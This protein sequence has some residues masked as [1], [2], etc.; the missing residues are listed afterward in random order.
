MT[1]YDQFPNFF[2]IGAPKSG[3]TSMQSYLSQHPDV[4][5]AAGEPHY[6]G[7][8]LKYNNVP[9]ELSEYKELFKGSS[10]ER[11]RG[12]K[13]A[14]YLYSKLAAS[15][16]H[17]AC[18]NAKILATLR[19]PIDVVRSLHQYMYHKN[20]RENQRDLGKALDLEPDRRNGQSI[21]KNARF[22]EHLFYSEIAKY[23]DQLERYY[24]IFDDSQIKVV[25][26]DDFCADPA[27]I[28]HDVYEFLGVRTDFHP[29][30]RR[31]NE[32]VVRKS[33]F[34]DH[35]LKR[36]AIAKMIKKSS[37][38]CLYTMI[39]PFYRS[40]NRLNTDR[41]TVTPSA[42]DLLRLRKM[43]SDDIGRLETLLGRDLSM[44]IN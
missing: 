44:W 29:D 37:P 4:F 19:N 24:K 31:V 6:F 10:A 21:P 2:M 3:T 12:E 13:S 14:W 36:S 22:P 26:F 43:Y 40:V 11:L 16:I 17:A 33:K 30:M 23:S 18:P 7:T 35:S 25:I 20:G 38:D 41:Q 42:D 39:R 32:T 27:G 1:E 15:E 9:M 5:M 34:L 8:D 28:V